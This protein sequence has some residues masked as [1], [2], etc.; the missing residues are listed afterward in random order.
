MTRFC[1]IFFRYIL[2]VYYFKNTFY[3]LF[4]LIASSFLRLVGRERLLRKKHN[5]IVID[6]VDLK[7][8][9]IHVAATSGRKCFCSLGELLAESV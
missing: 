6:S 4:I 8:F 2:G 5:I 1:K 3:V 7:Y 9:C